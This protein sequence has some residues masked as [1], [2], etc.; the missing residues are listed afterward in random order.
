MTTSVLVNCPEHASWDVSCIITDTEFNK[1][2][3]EVNVAPGESTMLTIWENRT[4]TIAE[5][6]KS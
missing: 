3:Q 5:K 1:V 6:P 2:V 4:L